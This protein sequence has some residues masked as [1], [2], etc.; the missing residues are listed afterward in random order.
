MDSH[1]VRLATRPSLQL[2]LALSGGEPGPFQ[3]RA[4]GGIPRSC[5]RFPWKFQGQAGNSAAEYSW[6]VRWRCLS[7]EQSMGLVLEKLEGGMIVSPRMHTSSVP[8]LASHASKQ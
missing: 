8:S 4:E 1:G 7:T 2:G 3:H 6:A 5:R